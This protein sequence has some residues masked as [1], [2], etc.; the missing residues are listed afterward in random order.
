LQNLGKPGEIIK[1]DKD[2]RDL[3]V[4]A[5]SSIP[6]GIVIS[7]IIDGVIVDVNNAFLQ[8][9]ECRREEVLGVNTNALVIFES[10]LQR[11]EL[12]SMLM[13]GAIRELEINIRSRKGKPLTVLVSTERIY[14]NNEE[15]VLSTIIDITE[16]K[17][18]ERELKIS[19][20]KYRLLFS[21]MTNGFTFCKMIYDKLGKPIDFL[22][23]EVND[24]FETLTGLKKQSVV[25]KQ[26]TTVL[27]TI[28]QEHPE[29]FEIYGKVAATGT[30]EK[31]E[32][33]FKPLGIW[34][35]I[36]V[37]SP[38]IEYFV[39]VFDNITEKKQI[40]KLVEEY[41]EGLE[42][43]VAERTQELLEAQSRL[44]KLE[45]LSAI[46]ELAGM[47]G[48]D[49]RNPLTGIKNA[50]YVLRKNKCTLT[51]QN[52]NEMLNAIDRCV[53]HANNIIGDLLE[54]SRE[55]HLDLEE[56]SPK[57]IINYVLLAIKPP[58]NIKI[59]LNTQDNPHLWVD[60]N[61][62]ERVFTNIIKNAF[63]AMPNGGTLEI[64][65]CQNNQNVDFLFADTG[66]GMCSEVLGK[67]FTPL[68]TT[69]AQ[70]MGFGLA[71]CKRIIEAHEGK[72][73]VESAPKKG[74][75]F[76]ISLP[77]QHNT[78]KA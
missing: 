21:H 18:A 5:F 19:E 22:Y 54:Y 6:V 17:K 65:S 23:L 9:I 3:F 62:I 20:Q 35:S 42:L 41:S 59:T 36:S 53:D 46:G 7:R 72:I 15:Y 47:V 10:D 4:S 33:F 24:A 44:L 68:F 1:A 52:T 11:A 58:D 70:G 69:K 64:S 29:L 12:D 57:T 30:T 27:P 60:A 51:G 31:I 8:L 76:T 66:N 37:Y 43:T 50:A 38:Q 26:A 16:R 71:I 28:K 73:V 56:Y 25:G 78:N 45:R 32:I 74:T 75:V 34:L 13:K 48:H 39:A 67:I 63:E 61:K 49:L 14:L 77:I 2:N 40:D 55:I